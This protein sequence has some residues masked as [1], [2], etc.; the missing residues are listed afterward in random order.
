MQSDPNAGLS[1]P[2]TKAAAQHAAWR[3][4]ARESM[5]ADRKRIA[6]LQSQGLTAEQAWLEL[7]NA[8]RAR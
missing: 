1:K 4:A 2:Q 5:S 7:F 6:A 3:A 8:Q